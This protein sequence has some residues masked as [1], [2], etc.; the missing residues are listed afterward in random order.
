V[1]PASDFAELA[2]SLPEFRSGFEEIARQRAESD[3]A[4]ASDPPAR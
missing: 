3:A 1:L 2:G 4:H